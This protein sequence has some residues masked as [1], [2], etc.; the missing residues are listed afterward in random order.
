MRR[1]P[2]RQIPSFRR[3]KAGHTT[4]PMHRPSWR[5]GDEPKDNLLVRF[6]DA[7]TGRW[8]LILCWGLLAVPFIQLGFWYLAAW[9][10]I[11]QDWVLSFAERVAAFSWWLEGVLG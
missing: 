5:E 7:F 4:E 2:N 11:D 8:L 9:G 3:L 1:N 6:T 10:V